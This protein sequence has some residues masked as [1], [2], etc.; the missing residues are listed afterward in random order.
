MTEPKE[1][2]FD[3]PVLNGMVA[4]LA[5]ALGVGII[6]AI[7]ALA[8]SRV[9]GLGDSDGS[10]AK[11]NN[12]KETA[13]IPSPVETVEETGPRITLYTEDPDEATSTG[14]SAS[15]SED[16]DSEDAESDEASSEAT[17]KTDGISLQAAASSV[18]SGERIYFSGVYPSGEGAVLQLQRFQDGAWVRFPATVNVTNGTFSSYLFTGQSGLNRFRVIDSDSGVASNEIRVRVG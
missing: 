13:V 2:R 8:G 10:T 9:L 6:L 18:D 11:D 15:G 16:D 12:V 7:V 17:A 5:V 14:S 4:L 1:P 3:R